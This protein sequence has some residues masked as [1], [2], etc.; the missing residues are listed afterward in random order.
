MA[1]QAINPEGLFKASFYSQGV[2][3]GNTLHISGQV[4]SIAG[5]A[6]GGGNDFAAEARQALENIRQVV[7]QAGGAMA[8]VVRM[9]CFLTDMEQG[10]LLYPAIEAMFP[11]VKP[12]VTAIV[13][14]S[15]GSPKYKLEIEA[16]AVLE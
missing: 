7:E 9:T 3:V 14:K 8:D 2:R 1:K 15:I 16:T 13:V 10:R 12:A 11:G 4:G 5:E 6:A